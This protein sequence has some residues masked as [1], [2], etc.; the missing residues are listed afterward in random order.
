[1]MLV[2]GRW[3]RGKWENKGGR[4]V[5][6]AGAYVCDVEVGLEDGD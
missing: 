1:M 4:E 2:M 5:P 3:R 6:G